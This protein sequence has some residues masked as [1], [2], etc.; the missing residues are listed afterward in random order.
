MKEKNYFIDGYKVAKK[1][2]KF[3]KEADSICIS[4]PAGID[5]FDTRKTTPIQAVKFLSYQYDVP[6]SVV[7]EWVD[8][9][10]CQHAIFALN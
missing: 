1:L 5:F 2:E 3:W 7:G 9:M 10:T 8:E 6:Y 4:N